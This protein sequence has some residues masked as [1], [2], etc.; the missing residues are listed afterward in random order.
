VLSLGYLG[1]QSVNGAALAEGLYGV[2]TA[3]EL[4]KNRDK[5]LHR[6]GQPGIGPVLDVP[7]AHFPPRGQ[8]LRKILADPIGY[9][10]RPLHI[11]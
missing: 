1:H 6:G 5:L 2:R 8:D 9:V 10:R 4:D 11:S 3:Q 7:A